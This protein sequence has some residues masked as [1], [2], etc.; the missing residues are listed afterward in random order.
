MYTN[1]MNVY[2]G[3]VNLGRTAIHG[4]NRSDHEPDYPDPRKLSPSPS[5]PNPSRS[6]SVKT[7][8]PLPRS[9]RYDVII[10]WKT[11]KL[12]MISAPVILWVSQDN[13]LYGMAL[14]RIP[15]P[16]EIMPVRCYHFMENP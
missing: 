9:C 14:G 6:E 13:G 1:A 4:T 10:L 15:N 8:G 3:Y 5:N 7:L 2:A 16:S 12:I 11:H